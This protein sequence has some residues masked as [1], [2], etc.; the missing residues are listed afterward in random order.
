MFESRGCR[1]DELRVVQALS[2]GWS[3]L[4]RMKQLIDA[5]GKIRGSDRF[6]T[7]AAL[8][9]RVKNI[10]KGIEDDRRDLRDVRGHL[11][12]PAELA[13][14]DQMIE[15][16]PALEQAL[17]SGHFDDAVQMLADFQPAVDQFFK[18]VLVMAEEPSL[19]DARLAL[20]TK[21]RTAVLGSFG[22]ISE[23]AAEGK[24]A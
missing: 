8:F 24:P 7:L 13:L 9:K 15:R 5:L 12:E 20:L 21:L 18:D 6:E 16:W 3:V 11:R 4:D 14:A 23:I 17:G 10:T 19:R 22:D 1:S 2:T